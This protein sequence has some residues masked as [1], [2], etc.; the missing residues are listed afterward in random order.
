MLSR[1]VSAALACLAAGDKYIGARSAQDVNEHE[2]HGSATRA[3][4]YLGNARPRDHD[5]CLAPH[6]PATA[7]A[8]QSLA[9]LLGFELKCPPFI[10]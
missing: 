9:L 3:Y 8:S 6:C 1:R 2:Q 7:A 4:K 10:A 5:D